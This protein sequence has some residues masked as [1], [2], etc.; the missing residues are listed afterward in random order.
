M[1]HLSYILLTRYDGKSPIS[2]HKGP[3]MLGAFPSHDIIMRYPDSKVGGPTWGPPGAGRTQVG[4]MLAPWTLLSGYPT[5]RRN[6][7]HSS[8]TPGRYG[9]D[10]KGTIFKFYR[11][12]AWALAMNFLSVE[13]YRISLM[14]SQHLCRWYRQATSH[15]LSQCWPRS[16]SL[17][18]VT[19]PQWVKLICLCMHV[20]HRKAIASSDCKLWYVLSSNSP[21]TM[22]TFANRMTSFNIAH[23]I[24]QRLGIRVINLFLYH[25]LLL[26]VYL[27]E[28]GLYATGIMYGL[29]LLWGS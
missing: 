3:V 8:L 9:N 25:V 10:S 15:Y 6:T 28:S 17:C 5:F 27:S 26:T 20:C 21:H 22:R 29:G 19:R 7:D 18:G 14:I 24:L 11:I 2:S 13:C 23:T 12:S 4:P 1:E 16:M